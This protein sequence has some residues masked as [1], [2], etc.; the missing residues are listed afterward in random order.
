[1]GCQ[2]SS[3]SPG[4]A[5]GLLLTMTLLESPLKVATQSSVPVAAFRRSSEPRPAKPHCRRRDQK[6]DHERGW[7]APEACAPSSGNAASAPARRLPPGA[8]PQTR[9]RFGSIFRL[10]TRRTRSRGEWIAIRSV[11]GRVR[12]VTRNMKWQGTAGAVTKRRPPATP[13]PRVC[14]DGTR[15]GD[16]K[17]GPQLGM[18]GRMLH[19]PG[20][21]GGGQGVPLWRAG[22][23]AG[24]P[25]RGPIS[26]APGRGISRAAGAR[27]GQ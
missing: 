8:E 3:P 25:G 24:G 6:F 27:P 21:A 5:V 11:S 23:A 4:S 20:F 26:H 12:L 15:I 18:C 17:G 13:Q 10:C 22:D 19:S 2:A 14:A 1:M 16:P 7:P 9:V